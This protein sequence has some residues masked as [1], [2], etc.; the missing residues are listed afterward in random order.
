MQI[1]CIMDIKTLGLKTTK[2]REGLLEIFE[3]QK[4]PIGVSDYLKLLKKRGVEADQTTIYRSLN[5][6]INK[7]LVREIYF[8]DGLVR[9]ELSSKPE[10]HHAVCLKCGNIEDILDCSVEQIEKQISKKKGF[11]IISHSLEFFGVCKKC[12][13]KQS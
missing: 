2:A 13:T 12:K 3:H 4:K 7:G 1:D 10:H 5:T 6:F 11:S 9:Y 8:N